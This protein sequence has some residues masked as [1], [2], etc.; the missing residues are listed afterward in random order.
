MNC[1]N[2]MSDSMCKVHGVKVAS[3]YTCDH[4]E[5]KAELTDHRDCTSCQRYERDDCANPAKAS[6][7]MMCSVWAPRE[8]R[9]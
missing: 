2:M 5:M 4:F 6:P 3:H 8:F 7:G 9:A 1:D